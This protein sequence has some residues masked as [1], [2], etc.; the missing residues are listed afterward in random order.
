VLQNVVTGLYCNNLHVCRKRLENITKTFVTRF[1]SFTAG[2]VSVM[3]V[4]SGF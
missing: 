3:D 4:F 2:V 1:Q